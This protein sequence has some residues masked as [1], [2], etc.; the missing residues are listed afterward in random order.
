MRIDLRAFILST[1]IASS[2]IFLSGCGF[3]AYAVSDS[4]GDAYYD[5]KDSKLDAEAAQSSAELDR[6]G[7]MLKQASKD[8][9]ALKGQG[10]YLICMID[11]IS[12]SDYAAKINDANP[13]VSVTGAQLRNSNPQITSDTIPKWTEV[14]VPSYCARYDPGST[15]YESPT[16]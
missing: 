5:R 15:S 7:V 11:N 2:S 14:L 9:Y 4:T 10:F 12:V 3:L 8:D 6:L 13:G 1:A 16:P